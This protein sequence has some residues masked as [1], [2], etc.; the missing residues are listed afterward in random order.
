MKV[1]LG[2]WDSW[3]DDAIVAD[4]ETGVFGDPAKVRQLDHQGRWYRSKGPFTVP[5]SA[6]GRP[7]IIQAG[8]S[9]RGQLFA[10]QWAELVFAVLPN[11][12]V[13]KR[14]Y[15]SFKDLVAAQGRDPAKVRLAPAVYAIAAET[16]AAAEDK[17]ALIDRLAKPVDSLALLSEALNFDFASKDMDAAFTDD[18]LKSISGLRAILDRVVNLSG[19][20]NPTIRDFVQ[21]SRRGTLHEFPIFVGSAKDVADQ[22]EAWH[23]TA[24]DGFVLAATHLPGSYEDFVRLV[25]PELQRRGLHQKDYKGATLRE[26]LGLGRAEIDDWKR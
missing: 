9:G 15:K 20:K 16:R 26:T 13:G 5:R 18:E 23:G 14:T 24:C 6:Q 2:H 3:A 4:K 21:F 10:A 12:E 8:Q 17:M 1:V 19:K 11:I 22:M 7:V 25:V